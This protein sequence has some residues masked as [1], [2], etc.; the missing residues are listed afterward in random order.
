MSLRCLQDNNYQR[1][2]CELFFANYTN[3]RDFWV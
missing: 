1:E 3:C 2:K